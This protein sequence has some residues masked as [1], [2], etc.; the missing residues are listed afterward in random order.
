MTSEEMTSEFARVSGRYG[1]TELIHCLTEAC[2]KDPSFSTAAA[3]DAVKA[4]ESLVRAHTNARQATSTWLASCSQ[5]QSS[6]QR[7][8]LRRRLL[9]W[10]MNPDPIKMQ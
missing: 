7:R 8:T 9:I 4:F 10:R 2:S 5:Q 3:T 1:V 6:M